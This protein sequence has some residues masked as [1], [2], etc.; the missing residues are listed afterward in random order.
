MD[1]HISVLDNGFI[2]GFSTVDE[3]DFFSFKRE[4]IEKKSDVIKKV[5]ELLDEGK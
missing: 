2:L 5:R 3:N 4:A 1:I